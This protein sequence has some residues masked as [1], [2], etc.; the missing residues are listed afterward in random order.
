MKFAYISSSYLNYLHEKDKHTQLDS[1]GVVIYRSGYNVFI[2][3]SSKYKKFEKWEPNHIKD[4]YYEIVKSPRGKSIAVL[5]IRDY[6]ICD[7]H[8]LNTYVEIST[9]L[10]RN[11]LIYVRKNIKKIED[12]IDFI[13]EYHKRVLNKRKRLSDEYYRICEPNRKK[14][15]KM[16]HSKISQAIESMALV[17]GIESYVEFIPEVITSANIPVVDTDHVDVFSIHQI[18]NLHDAWS[19]MI[20]TIIIGIDADYLIKLN[21]IVAKG[22][23]L[24]TG[25]L[26]KDQA[27]VSGIHEIEPIDAKELNCKVARLLSGDKNSS[28]YL[29]KILE[30]YI[31]MIV[32]QPFYDGNKRTAFIVLNKLLLEN[33][34]GMIII[35]EVQIKSYNQLLNEHYKT[36]SDETLNNLIK[37]LKDEC[38][39]Y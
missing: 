27:Y 4:N 14:Y 2:P 34:I 7:I 19:Y 33:S 17:E 20:E 22:E 29:H 6:I 16:A 32:R 11:E 39:I 24:Y 5:K 18:K 31:F 12:K 15:K 35:R 9:N 13:L 28:Q 23:A 30:F 38:L 37:F 10:Q 25:T 8:S 26:R 36:R 3:I 21:S 1:F